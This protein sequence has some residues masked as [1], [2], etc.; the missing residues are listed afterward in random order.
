MKK[1]VIIVILLILGIVYYLYSNYQDYNKLSKIYG[2][3]EIHQVSLAFEESGRIKEL[4]YREGAYVKK[5]EF[6][7]QI[8]DTTLQL[9]LN[10]LKI[11]LQKSKNLLEKLQNGSRI[12]EIELAKE[13][14]NKAIALNKVA[15]LDYERKHQMFIKTNGK[16]ISQSEVDAAL[17]QKDANQAE[18]LALK[19]N[20]NLLQEGSRK[21][22]IEDAKLNVKLIESKI[23]SL[24]NQIS[25]TTLIAPQDGIIRS[26]YQEVG[27][28]TSPSQ[29]VYSILLNNQKWV[30][31]YVS[32]V[33]LEKIKLGD[34]VKLSI[35]SLD[36]DIQFDGTIGFISG[37]SEFTPKNIETPDL[38]TNLVYEIKIE[39]ND[40]KDKLKLGMPVTV[41]LL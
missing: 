6:L 40:P 8:D 27:D 4:K 33:L 5:G 37:V 19:Q 29:L 41:S 30:R 36:S 3:V 26:R 13:T 31:A 2:N 38:R 16:G 11:E 20:L 9:Q 23:A 34:K 21:E 24:E 14:L 17:S 35:D 28:L 39:V 15:I 12:Q 32:E 18:V 7:A 10:S 25:K 22:D 1:I